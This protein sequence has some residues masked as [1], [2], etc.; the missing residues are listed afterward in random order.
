[1]RW[2]CMLFVLALGC[3]ANDPGGA[4]AA[5]AVD[6]GPSASDG[7]GGAD[8]AGPSLD[9]GSSASDGG[10]DAAATGPEVC[11]TDVDE[12]GDGYAGCED[13]E[14]WDEA[15]CVEAELGEV[16][17]SGWAACGD[18]IAFDAAATATRC[19]GSMP[20]PTMRDLDCG[21]VPTEVLA[22][23]F[24]EPAGGEGRALR[25]RVTMDTTPETEMIGPMASRSTSFS[26]ELG[27]LGRL[28][29]SSGATGSS[30]EDP[31]PTRDAYLPG[32]SYRASA[33]GTGVSAGGTVLVF[34]G[35]SAQTGTIIIHDDGSVDATNE[36]PRFFLTAGFEADLL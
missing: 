20:F 15:A 21:R 22:Q 34:L 5:A 11:T 9:G 8:A 17:L 25:Y 16:G 23:V 2:L 3:D 30:G 36:D 19:A 4:D 27:Y 24:C 28:F 1:M 33:W 6:A 10:H 13:A 18:P 26:P 35:A 31:V 32:S 12:D 14:C 29:I 7:G